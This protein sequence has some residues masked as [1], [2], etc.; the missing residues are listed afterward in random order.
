MSKNMRDQHLLVLGSSTKVDPNKNGNN[1]Q[2]AAGD[3]ADIW[4]VKLNVQGQTIWEKRY[5]FNG[6]DAG[7]SIQEFQGEYYLLAL[8]K[9]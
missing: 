1:G 4:L 8:K 6:F 3:I 7:V 9:H 2:S 5:G